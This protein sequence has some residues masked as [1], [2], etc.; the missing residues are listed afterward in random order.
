MRSI[1]RTYSYTMMVELNLSEE[2]A[3]R[4]TK[5]VPMEEL[6][7]VTVCQVAT[8]KPANRWDGAHGGGGMLCGHDAC[9]ITGT[10]H[11]GREL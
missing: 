10:G 5:L 7:A 4:A 11:M 3:K 8:S 9:S 6:K 1:Q 2:P